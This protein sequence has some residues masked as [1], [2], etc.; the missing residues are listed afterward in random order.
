MADAFF[1]NQHW[2]GIEFLVES[3][4]SVVHRLLGPRQRLLRA[5]FDGAHVVFRL[6][7]AARLPRSDERPMAKAARIVALAAKPLTAALVAPLHRLARSEWRTRMH[8]P[9]GSAQYLIFERA[10]G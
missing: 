4:P 3:E 8:D 7:R 2:G 9:T 6:H 5:G 10:T 1:S